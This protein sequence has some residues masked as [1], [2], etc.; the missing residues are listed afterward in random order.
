MLAD[1][2]GDGTRDQL[3][4][5]T[6]S[7]RANRHWCRA[8]LTR[9]SIPWWELPRAGLPADSGVATSPAPVGASRRM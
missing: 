8:D 2:V 3:L 5:G 9:G 4:I 1:P 7:P 6:T